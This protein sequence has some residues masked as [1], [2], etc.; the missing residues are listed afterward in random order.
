MLGLFQH[1]AAAGS[2]N[3]VGSILS[4]PNTLEQ[5]THIVSRLDQLM[6]RDDFISL[7]CRTPRSRPLAKFFVF[8][9]GQRRTA[10]VAMPMLQISE[11]YGGVQAFE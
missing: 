9:D 11:G 6:L 7:I 4:A 3:T 5:Y 10:A 8:A 1:I 2:G